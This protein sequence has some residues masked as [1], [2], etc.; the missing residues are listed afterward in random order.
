MSTIPELW[1]GEIVSF[2]ISDSPNLKMV[3]EMLKKPFGSKANYACLIM[4][5]DQGWHYQHKECQNML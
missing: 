3:T 1:N 4:H 5:S 2:T